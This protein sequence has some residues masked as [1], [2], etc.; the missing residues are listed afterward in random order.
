MPSENPT[1][2]L[3]SLLFKKKVYLQKYV[4]W[5]RLT[6]IW[7]SLQNIA[8]YKLFVMKS[9]KSLPKNKIYKWCSKISKS[10]SHKKSYYTYKTVSAIAAS[11]VCTAT[12]IKKIY[13]STETTNVQTHLLRKRMSLVTLETKVKIKFVSL[14]PG[15]FPILGKVQKLIEANDCSQESHQKYQADI[16]SMG[17]TI[18]WRVSPFGYPE[19]ILF[20]HTRRPSK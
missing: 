15:R 2:V 4:Q 3:S 6:N 8:S 5:K 9:L 13:K 18:S 10:N 11:F 7:E 19:G 1:T 17:E 12:R 16:I 20:L 14:P